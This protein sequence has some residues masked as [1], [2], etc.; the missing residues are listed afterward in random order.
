MKIPAD[1]ERFIAW[2]LPNNARRLE[3]DILSELF[4]G[5][6]IKEAARLRILVALEDEEN[7][8]H[9]FSIWQSA[10]YTGDKLSQNLGKNRNFMIGLV[11]VIS[12]LALLA[13]GV[14][15]IT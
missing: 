10:E 9:P 12:W 15:T 7:F 2:K 11:T 13:W 5:Q 1:R 8:Q 14:N 3:I 4:E 6:D